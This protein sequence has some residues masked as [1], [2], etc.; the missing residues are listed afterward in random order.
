MPLRVNYKNRIG[1]YTK[2]EK[3]PDEP[4]RKFKNWM[5]HANVDLWADMYFYKVKEDLERI[6]SKVKKGDKRVQFIA[7][8]TDTQHLKRALKDGAY[9]GADDFHFFAD[10]MNADIWKAVKILVE[11]GKKVTIVKSQKKKK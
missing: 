5:C 2:T 11:A 1:Y 7:F 8:W 3:W 4:D 10:Q 9:Q 6:G